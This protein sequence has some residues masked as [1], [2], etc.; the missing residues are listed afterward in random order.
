MGRVRPGEKSMEPAP[1]AGYRLLCVRE[2]C[3]GARCG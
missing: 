3:G 2:V 1:L